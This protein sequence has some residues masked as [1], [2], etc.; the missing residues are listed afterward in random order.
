M[1]GMG[2]TR[3]SCRTVKLPSII[4]PPSPRATLHRPK[5]HILSEGVPAPKSASV[6]ITRSR[7]SQAARPPLHLPISLALT[8]LR[9]CPRNERPA[10]S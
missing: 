2:E 1:Q 4:S 9:D 10:A 7:G 8:H 3:G 5:P 6:V